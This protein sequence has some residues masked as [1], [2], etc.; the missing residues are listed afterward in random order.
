MSLFH[1]YHFLNFLKITCPQFIE[2]NSR[3]DSITIRISAIPD[4]RMI[5]I[6]ELV[7][8]KSFFISSSS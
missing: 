1:Q 4:D 5:T 6:T 2:I 8:N 7:I 3:G